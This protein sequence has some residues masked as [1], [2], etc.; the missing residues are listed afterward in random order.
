MTL[1]KHIQ[2]NRCSGKF[3]GPPK[4]KVPKP[5]NLNLNNSGPE[6]DID[7][8]PT[9][10]SQLP[11][12]HKALYPDSARACHATSRDLEKVPHRPKWVCPIFSKF[13]L[14]IVSKLFVDRLPLNPSERA[15]WIVKSNIQKSQDVKN[16]YFRFVRPAPQRVWV[17]TQLSYQLCWGLRPP[18]NAERTVVIRKAVTEKMAF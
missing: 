18:P 2:N 13:D 12:A 15:K 5:Q 1:L 9:S 16:C 8:I 4:V 6:V 14:A 7:P 17:R 10:F 11:G 3:S